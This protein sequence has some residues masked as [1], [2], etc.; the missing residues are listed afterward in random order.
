MENYQANQR[1]YNHYVSYCEQYFSF[2][3]CPTFEEWAEKNR[4]FT[5][6]SV[7]VPRQTRN[8]EPSEE[9]TTAPL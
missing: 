9:S 5:L 7:E 4:L 8:L 1:C 6:R 3:P 2:A